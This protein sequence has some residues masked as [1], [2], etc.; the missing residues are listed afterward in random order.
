MLLLSF[1]DLEH[2]HSLLFWL[3][4]KKLCFFST[5]LLFHL[6]QV[7]FTSS[8]QFP[9][10]SLLHTYYPI[11]SSTP[12]PRASASLPPRYPQYQLHWLLLVVVLYLHLQIN[13]SLVPNRTLLCHIVLVLYP[14]PWV[15][16]SV[17]CSLGGLDPITLFWVDLL[18]I[19]K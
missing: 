14:S 8:S 13:L 18:R 7:L 16:A 4:S 11:T 3:L 15:F 10:S 5:K 12:Y 2:W 9:R 19:A 17:W 1:T 6:S